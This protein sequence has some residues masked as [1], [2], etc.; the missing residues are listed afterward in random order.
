MGAGAV[1]NDRAVFDLEGVLVLGDASV[2]KALA[3]EQRFEPFFLFRDAC[4]SE[5]CE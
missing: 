1:R 2:L 3:V 5:G 4:G